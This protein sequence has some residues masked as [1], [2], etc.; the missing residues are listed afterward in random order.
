[1][2]TIFIT[3]G[4][5][6]IGRA[7]AT[8]FHQKGW[9]VACFDR[10]AARLEALSAA[11]DGL[12][13][14]AGD[15][16]DAAAVDAALR[17]FTRR[18][19]GALDVLHNNAGVVEVGEFDQVPLEQ[20]RRVIDVNLT[21]LVT[22]THGALPYLKRSGRAVVVNMSSA[23]ALYGHPEIATYAATK[24]A[25]RSLT[26]GWSIAFAK[27]G[28]RVTD[29]LPIY[30]KTRMV[31]DYHHLYRNLD[32]Q[33]V[34]LTP[35]QIA[36]RVWTAVHGQRLHY[37]VGTDTKLYAALLRWLPRRWAPPVVRRVLGYYE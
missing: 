37:L 25:I 29:L 8:L 12:H 32:A 31:S 13:A 24:A 5:Q 22:V 28:I 17:D 26:E 10:D 21:G 2:R 4:A 7:T 6:G 15:V 35:E 16:T 27:H 20:H 18:S 1:M 34:R 30:V 19:A 3:G 14:Y 36:A 11:L 9:Q 23:S 33:R